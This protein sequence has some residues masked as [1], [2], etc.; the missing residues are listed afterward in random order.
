MELIA[1]EKHR[2][3]KLIGRLDGNSSGNLEQVLMALPEGAGDIIL[4][5][6]ECLYLSS[7]GIRVLLAAQKRLSPFHFQ[8]FLTGVK[9]EV[10]HIFEMA[11]L[12]RVLRIEADV[13]SALAVIR[14]E[15]KEVAAETVIQ[16]KDKALVY[17]PSGHGPVKVKVNREEE[18]LSYREMDGGIGFGAVTGESGS[19]C[20]DFFVTLGHCTGFVPADQS[21]D[22]DFR[23]TT[24]PAKTGFPVWK[25]LSFGNQPTGYLKPADGGILSLPMLYDAVRILQE[26]TGAPCI[27]RYFITVSRG[28]GHPSLTVALISDASWEQYNEETG[29]DQS[30]SFLIRQEK[31]ASDSDGLGSNTP[32]TGMDAG[33]SFAGFTFYLVQAEEI[34]EETTLSEFL[35]RCLTFENITC[36][37][38][39]QPEFLL[40][41]PFIWLFAPEEYADGKSGRLI[42]E[43][44]PGVVFEQHKRFLARLLYDDSARLV[45]NP[46]H[47]GYSAQTYQVNSYDREGRKMRPTVLKIAGR[48]LITRESERCQ[49]FALPYIFNN[50]AMVLGTA[51]YGE[52]MA[53]RY[54]FVGIGGESSQ[55]KWL[56]H[57]YLESDIGFLEPLFDRIFLQILKPWYGQPVRK[58]I[59][60][61]QDHDPTRT[62]F[63]HIYQTAREVL[64][65][66]DEEPYLQIPESGR[67]VLNP[68]RFLKQEYSR[69]QEWH[70]TYNTGICHGDLN[71]QNILLDE[72]M[73][74]YLIDFSETRPRPVISDFARLE[75]IFLVDNAP[76]E[77]EEDMA[78]YLEFIKRFYDCDNLGDRPVVDYT[79]KHLQKVAK[80]AALTIKMRQYAFVSAGDDRDMVPYYLALLEWVLPIVCY[81]SMPYALKRLSMIVSSLLC[82]KVNDHSFA[83][84]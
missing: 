33:Y 84:L 51:Q 13:E 48:S 14:A 80:N 42:I 52:T 58:T 71:M 63:P 28:A 32:E 77:S 61:F 9:P 12:Q 39:L 30:A 3:L 38:L 47:G 74:I 26:K 76:V 59:F 1:D 10:N 34:T 73:N 82:E 53:L 19:P 20:R 18:I 67:P 16:V 29:F 49:K 64:G 8:L 27:A 54:N 5:F 79:G 68:Y 40:E 75:A 11:G 17:R 41:N 24:E 6:S 2:C 37:V 72:K 70:T 45:I 36:V 7:A 25:A 81:T 57:Y 56:T 4:D 44:A 35:R 65:I 15:T 21:A 69:R 62:F 46:L 83:Q 23:I 22:P 66:S 78:A 43:T 60:P 55:L 31:L 50:C